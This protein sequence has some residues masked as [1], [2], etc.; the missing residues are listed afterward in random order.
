MGLQRKIGQ[1]ETEGMIPST[2]SESGE[3]EREI[4][5]NNGP[6][7][8]RLH[9]IRMWRWLEVMSDHLHARERKEKDASTH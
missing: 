1:R 3:R 5:T 8:V 4:I 7:L 6:W 9:C 2:T